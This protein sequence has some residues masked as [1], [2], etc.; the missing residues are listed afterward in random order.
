MNPVAVTRTYG[1]AAKSSERRFGMILK[2]PLIERAIGFGWAESS[3]QD[4]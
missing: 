4:S 2:R 1:E 3:F